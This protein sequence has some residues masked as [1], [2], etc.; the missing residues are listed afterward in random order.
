MRPA[1]RSISPSPRRTTRPFGSV[2][3]CVAAFFGLLWALYRYRLHQL[4]REFNAQLEGR[5]DERTRIA[6]E[7]HD[8]L[9]QSFQAALFEFQA[10][11]NLFSKGREEAIQTLDSA[12]S[13]AQDAIVEGRDAIHDLR[14]TVAPHAHLEQLLKTAGQELASSHVSDGNRPAFR[15]TVEGPAQALSPVLQDEVYQ[16]GREVLRNAFRHASAS[17]IEAEIRYSDR[18]LRLRIRDDGKGIDRK[19][20]EDGVPGHWGL[21]GIRE[22]A[23]RIGARLVFWSEAG[24]GTEVELA[25]PSA[26]RLCEIY[27][28]A[29]LWAVPEG[30]VTCRELATS[31]YFGPGR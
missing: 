29:S 12:I 18:L 24:A 6:R 19:V 23:K 14:D 5:V 31:T 26:N 15:V 9:L 11:R 30:K 25:V 27:C 4:A 2:C 3:H 8:T 17:R 28:P 10:A 16:I 1:T 13:T 22:R 7:L 21:P 20:L